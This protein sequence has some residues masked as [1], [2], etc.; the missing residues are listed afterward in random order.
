MKKLTH[1]LLL[2]LLALALPLQA[3]AAGLNDLCKIACLQQASLV[4]SVAKASPVIDH[5]MSMEDG[6]DMPC[7]DTD[8]NTNLSTDQGTDHQHKACRHCPPVLS[9]VAD[10]VMSIPFLSQKPSDQPFPLLSEPAGAFIADPLFKPP[11]T[12]FL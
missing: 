11:R 8:H 12:A 5:D 4:D 10:L 3:M 9:G 2:I 6:S 1:H 7:H